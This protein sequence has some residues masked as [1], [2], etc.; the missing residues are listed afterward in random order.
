M[1]VV[2]TCV[3]LV[4]VVLPVQY[5][6]CGPRVDAGRSLLMFGLSSGTLGFGAGAVSAAR[7]LSSRASAGRTGPRARRAVYW[8]C[9]NRARYGS[10]R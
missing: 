5:V 4:N 2:C 6:R 3:K 9:F 1:S 10:R 7:M 8:T